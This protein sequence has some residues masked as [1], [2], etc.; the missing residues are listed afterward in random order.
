MAVAVEAPGVAA[1]I[2][3]AECHAAASLVAQWARAARAGAV[4]IL[5]DPAISTDP[6]T[7]T[8][9]VIGTAVSG[10]GAIIGAAKTGTA[11]IGTAAKIGMGI[12]ITM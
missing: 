9:P 10:A 3:R 7:G 5:T 2:L 12:I 6:A 1:A 11:T 8:G 4:L